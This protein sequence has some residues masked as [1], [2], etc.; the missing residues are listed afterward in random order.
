ML[1]SKSHESS[2]IIV[3][4]LLLLGGVLQ[5]DFLEASIYG[6]SQDGVLVQVRDAH[7]IPYTYGVVLL[8]SHRDT[9]N[10]NADVETHAHM[11]DAPGLR[12]DLHQTLSLLDA[13]TPP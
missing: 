3:L 10:R 8:P 13:D 2:T 11:N 12:V 7:C 9:L 6:V 5:G 4:L 1:S